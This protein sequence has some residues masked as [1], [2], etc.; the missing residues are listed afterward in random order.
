[1]TIVAEDRHRLF[2]PPTPPRQPGKATS[3]HHAASKLLPGRPTP[4]EEVAV[5]AL[6]SWTDE[7]AF[8]AADA[9]R[10]TSSEVDFGA[11][12]RLA[13]SNDAWRLAWIRDTGE[14]YI[15]RADG[16]DGSCTDVM[17]LAVLDDEA[18]VDALIDG[19]REL[20][21]DPD[22]LGWLDARLNLVAAA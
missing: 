9:R 4:D 13:G 16:Y 1:M 12:W 18:D 21:T 7:V 8:A 22:G 15:C 17:V 6:S 2:A 19:W 10:R 3:V 20:R 5:Q 11:T 14:L